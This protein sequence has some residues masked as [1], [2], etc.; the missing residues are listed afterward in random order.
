[1]LTAERLRELLDY[2]A[3]TGVFRW[4][5]KR[6]N[7]CKAAGSIAGFPDERY[8][9]IGIA[10]RTYRAHRLAWLWMTSHWPD[11]EIDH[12]NGVKSDNR[13]SNLRGA[14]RAQNMRNQGPR[15]DNTL[16]VKGVY[17][18]SPNRYRVEIRHHGKLFRIGLFKTTEE[19][20]EA[21]GALARQLHGEFCHADA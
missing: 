19:A 1:M 20:R 4:R 9:R 14:T 2:D 5:H 18:V 7:G 10:R 21:H 13:W 11:E 17:K 15:K 6:G 16:G 3:E 12:I 8:I